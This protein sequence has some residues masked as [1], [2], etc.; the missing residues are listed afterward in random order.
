MKLKIG[1]LAKMTEVTKRTIDY[2]TT[3]G[4]L[5]AER[6]AANYR[7]YDEHAVQQIK[8]IE[9]CKQK[10]M[11]LE[12]IKESLSNK[13]MET[14]DIEHIKKMLESLDKE[15]KGVLTSFEGQN[16][17]KNEVRN[18]ISHESISLIQ[19]LLLLLS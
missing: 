9:E 8:F 14:V 19:T 13:K 15:I 16:H 1:E 2:Y 11:T 18:T 4:L 5:Q 7:Y 10:K 12:E 17:K 6:S 3:L